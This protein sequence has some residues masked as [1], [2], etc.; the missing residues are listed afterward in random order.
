MGIRPG[1]KID[2]FQDTLYPGTHQ[3]R[4]GRLLLPRSG[5]PDSRGAASHSIW[6]QQGT[7]PPCHKRQNHIFV[8]KTAFQTANRPR[9]KPPLR[10]GRALRAS[11]SAACTHH[12][13]VTVSRRSAAG[14]ALRQPLCGIQCILGL[15]Q[16][17]LHGRR[18][19]PNRAPRTPTPSFDYLL[20]PIA[21]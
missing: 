14:G 17:F 16:V 4:S 6:R 18:R 7:S 12:M 10:G 19:T 1:R 8:R 21:G 13:G 3:P 2:L 11:R 20:R 5:F 15:R 9:R